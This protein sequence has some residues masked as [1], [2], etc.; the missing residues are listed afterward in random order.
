M[1]NKCYYYNIRH[2][3]VYR[4]AVGHVTT[5]IVY[6][7]NEVC[8]QVLGASPPLSISP[9]F[10]LGHSWPPRWTT[11][12]DKNAIQRYSRSLG[13]NSK[14]SLTSHYSLIYHNTGHIQET[15]LRRRTA[16]GMMSITVGSLCQCFCE[17]I[18]FYSG[19]LTRAVHRNLTDFRP[20]ES[21]LCG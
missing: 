12:I 9:P 18:W 15:S 14:C 8:M 3:H 13:R 21:H 7:I 5:Y 2:M 6:R 1:C 11:R 17:Q 19:I 10:L 16:Y 20:I 4:I